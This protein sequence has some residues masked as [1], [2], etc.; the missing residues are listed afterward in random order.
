M[1]IPH[2]AV[3]ASAMLASNNPSTLQGIIGPVRVDNGFQ[4]ERSNTG[5]SVTGPAAAWRRLL[6]GQA[7]D[8]ERNEPAPGCWKGFLESVSRMIENAYDSDFE[9]VTLW[10]RGPNK[11]R[12]IDEAIRTCEIEA[13]RQPRKWPQEY[14]QTLN[15]VKRE[16]R[17]GGGNWAFMIAAMVAVLLGVPFGF[18]FATSYLTPQYGLSCRSLTHLTYFLAQIVQML[19]WYPVYC[20]DLSGTESPRRW[21]HVAQLLA[22]I[23]RYFP[24]G[25]FAVFAAVGGT[26]MQIT[27][28]YTN[29][30]CKVRIS[31]LFR[32]DAMC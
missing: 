1:V 29:C 8:Q 18:A 6:L 11:Q 17:P 27:G 16:F 14:R 2:T 15:E 24:V 31:Q 28:V 10:R 23:L 19:L 26:M 3:I 32:Q 7:S 4:N 13:A 21:K 25:L 30:L 9:P 20:M 22:R 5:G 12:W